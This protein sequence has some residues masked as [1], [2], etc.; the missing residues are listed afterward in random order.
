[1]SRLKSCSL[2]MVF[3]LTIVGPQ[4]IA[5]VQDAL[6]QDSQEENLVVEM[7]K[8]DMAAGQDNSK[9]QE[10]LAESFSLPKEEIQ[11]LLDAK[12]SYG[13]IAALLALSS[14][15]GKERPEVLGL[16][17][18]GKNWGEIADQLGVDLGAVVAK[19]QDVDSKLSTKATA[20]KKRKM[21]FPPGT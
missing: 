1:M 21:R 20:K 5:G 7:G 3:A 9:A 15:S 14:A 18:S 11:G 10:A 16:L 6:A 8:I 4:W 17:Q 13:N 12:L 19:V 2:L